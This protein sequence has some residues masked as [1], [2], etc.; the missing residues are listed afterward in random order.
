[1]NNI[2]I[3]HLKISSQVSKS[4]KC[5]L[6]ILNTKIDRHKKK[7]TVNVRRTKNRNLFIQESF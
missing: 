4:L 1:M 7:L 6:E 5:Y 3:L 2:L